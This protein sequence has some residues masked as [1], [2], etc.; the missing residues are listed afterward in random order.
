MMS[1]GGGQ[2]TP[3]PRQ[4]RPRRWSPLPSA[5]SPPRKALL[6]QIST[7]AFSPIVSALQLSVVNDLSQVS[8]SAAD[9]CPSL[10][11]RF[12]RL[13]I[14]PAS[15]WLTATQGQSEH[16]GSLILVGIRAASPI[17][18]WELY[19]TKS[20]LSCFVKFFLTRMLLCLV[21]T[22]RDRTFT[23]LRDGPHERHHL[24]VRLK[25]PYFWA[26]A[27]ITFAAM[28]L[29]SAVYQEDGP[30][31][32]LKIRCG[33]SPVAQHIWLHQKTAVP[34]I[35]ATVGCVSTTARPG[36]A[37]KRLPEHMQLAAGA[38]HHGGF[39]IVVRT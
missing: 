5:P 8:H 9:P 29:S 19:I 11:P 20:R 12:S 10:H 4:S 3:S 18:S 39:D 37:L 25:I 16:S 6:N 21:V 31:D 32:T 13:C 1:S 23:S 2:Q 15:F 7:R 36:L 38:E 28:V 33:K 26:R 14:C 30:H 35:I 34:Q 24:F 22:A 27:C 17:P